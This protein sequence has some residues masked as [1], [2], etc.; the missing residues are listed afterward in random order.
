MIQKQTTANNSVTY[1]TF[2]IAEHAFPA[3]EQNVGKIGHL[4]PDL[5]YDVTLFYTRVA[6]SI[7]CALFQ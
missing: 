4:P 3:F 6:G 2:S 1:L 5:A 7:V